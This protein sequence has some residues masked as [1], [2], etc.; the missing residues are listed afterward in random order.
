MSI[1]SNLVITKVI[2]CHQAISFFFRF[3]SNVLWRSE[4]GTDWTLLLTGSVVLVRSLMRLSCA[5]WALKHSNYGE[6]IW[7]LWDLLLAEAPWNDPGLLFDDFILQRGL[8][9]LDIVDVVFIEVHL[10]GA[11]AASALIN[12]G[13]KF[14]FVLQSSPLPIGLNS[15]LVIPVSLI[16]FLTRQELRLI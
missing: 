16:R 4:H 14:F 10:G 3:G 9:L 15:L 8:I 2:C 6:C 13:H 1:K 5:L 7:L 11:A 12:L